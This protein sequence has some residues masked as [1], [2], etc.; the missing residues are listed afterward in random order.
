VVNCQPLAWWE[1]ADC[2]AYLDRHHVPK[3]PLHD[4]A[5]AGGWTS[6]GVWMYVVD[7]GKIK[8]IES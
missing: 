8:L 1:F 2:F 4:Q 6:Q 5:R 3:H 7:R